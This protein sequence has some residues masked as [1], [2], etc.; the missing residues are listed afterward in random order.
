MRAALL[1][2]V[3][4]VASFTTGCADKQVRPEEVKA[5]CLRDHSKDYCELQGWVFET[6]G[7]LNGFNMTI[8]QNA[9]ARV[10]NKAQAQ[11]YLDR[12]VAVRKK[13]DLVAAALLDNN[14]PLTVTLKREALEL[15]IDL[16]REAAQVRQ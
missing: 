6:Y 7:W 3:L 12:S 16:Q 8:S 1:A 14:V 9:N 5:A 11:S 4:A 13:V 10:W 2:A 15:L